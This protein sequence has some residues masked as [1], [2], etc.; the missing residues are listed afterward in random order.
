MSKF[1]NKLIIEEPIAT[2]RLGSKKS[3]ITLF[4]ILIILII[5]VIFF[6][7]QKEGIIKL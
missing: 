6:I 3:I 2:K 1:K 5:L 7:L 4:I